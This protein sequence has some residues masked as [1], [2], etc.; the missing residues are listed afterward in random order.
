MKDEIEVTHKYTES[1]II[2]MLRFPIDY[3]FVEFGGHVYQQSMGI[4]MV[5]NC[6]PLLADTFLY[7]YETASCSNYKRLVPGNYHLISHTVILMTCYPIITLN[8]VITLTLYIR[9]NY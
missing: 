2:D 1:N 8:S 3:I 5:T 4:P 9:M 7:V 6:A